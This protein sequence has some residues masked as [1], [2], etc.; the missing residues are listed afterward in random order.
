METFAQIS[1]EIMRSILIVTLC[2]F[3]IGLRHH[4]DERAKKAGIR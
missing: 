1:I 4:L 3:C 2:A